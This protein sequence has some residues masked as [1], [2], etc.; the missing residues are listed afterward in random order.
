MY[1]FNPDSAQ[2]PR[3]TALWQRLSSDNTLSTTLSRRT[4]PHPLL[5][6]CCSS[7]PRW[8]A[9]HSEAALF[10]VC[11]CSRFISKDHLVIS[12]LFKSTWLIFTVIKAAGGTMVSPQPQQWVFFL[13]L[14]P[15]QQ[16]VW[17]HS[18]VPSLVTDKGRNWKTS[19]LNTAVVKALPHSWVHICLISVSYV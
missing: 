13:C 7:N 19:M 8:N 17:R 10:C 1:V 5:F 18:G 2:K 14:F 3:S 11:S 12:H 15:Q 16:S 9:L 4:S 6:I